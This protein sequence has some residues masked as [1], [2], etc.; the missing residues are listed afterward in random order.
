M[1]IHL[2]PPEIA[3]QIAAGE[4]VERPASV[5]KELVENALDAGAE[6]ITIKVEGAGRRLI[7]VGDDGCGIPAQELSL[8][9]YRHATSKLNTAADLFR[10]NTLGF[11]GEALASIGSV[12]RMTISYSPSGRGDGSPGE[13]GGRGGRR[14][15]ADWSPSWYL[16]ARRGSFFNVPARLK[17]LKTDTT[18]RRQIDELVTR[19]ALAYPQTR[20]HL[21]QEGQLTLQ[22]SGNGDRR[23]VLATL[24]GVDIARQMLEVLAEYDEMV[25]SGFIS[26]TSLTRS[27]RREIT[28]YVNGRWIQDVAVV[29]A[30]VQ[31]YHTMLMVGRYPLA[32]LFIDLPADQVDV[33]VHPAKSEVRFRDKDRVF[34]GVQR[35]VK[36]AL[37]AYTP[38][39]SLEP[40]PSWTSPDENAAHQLDLTKSMFTTSLSPGSAVTRIPTRCI[41]NPGESPPRRG[42]ATR[43]GTTFAP[44]WSDCW[45]VSGS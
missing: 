14:C 9:T 13:C 7:E 1:P 21:H 39:S 3:S 20:F 6:Y 37:L 11:R 15:P 28:I 27:N 16:G 43:A 36:R 4:V 29:S 35:A 45:G 26:P 22:T 30:V 38:V 31:A 42:G 12:S 41:F 25:I 18:E 5:V 40:R 32:A 10:I 2:L 8:A 17:F 34:S 44:C 23:E 19:Y 24:Y 33:N